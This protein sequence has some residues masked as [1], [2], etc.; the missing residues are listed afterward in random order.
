MRSQMVA[1]GGMREHRLIGLMQTMGENLRN[2]GNEVIDPAREAIE[3]K[4]PILM[5]GA[6]VAGAVRLL[7]NGPDHLWAGLVDE[8]IEPS[9]GSRTFDSI[10]QTGKNLVTLHPFRALVRALK[11]PGDVISDVTDGVLGFQG[12]SKYRATAAAETSL[13]QG[14]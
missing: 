7:M 10:G 6:P 5:V 11:I 4:D 1:F 12:S 13:Q 2:L 3:K 9:N 8:K 14:A